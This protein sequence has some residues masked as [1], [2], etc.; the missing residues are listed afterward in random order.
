MG[1]VEGKIEF[2]SVELRSFVFMERLIGF[3][4][5]LGENMETKFIFEK[6]F[7]KSTLDSITKIYT[8]LKDLRRIVKESNQKIVDLVVTISTFYAIL[9]ENSDFGFLIFQNK[10]ILKNLM[11]DEEDPLLRVTSNLC[12]IRVIMALE[13]K[14]DQNQEIQ[15][16]LE[17]GS[18]YLTSQ[19]VHF[20]SSEYSKY[21]VPEKLENDKD[22]S[23]AANLVKKE[24]IKNCQI[25]RANSILVAQFFEIRSP[26]LESI[27][28]AS[29]SQIKPE[30]LHNMIQAAS[31]PDIFLS[32]L[33]SSSF[34]NEVESMI[35]TAYSA[36]ANMMITNLSLRKIDMLPESFLSFE[37][38]YV[39]LA[40]KVQKEAESEKLDLW[41]ER[42]SAPLE[43]MT[44]FFI[45][46]VKY[47]KEMGGDLASQSK[48]K[49]NDLLTI[50]T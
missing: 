37:S 12:I 4:S 45:T 18:R 5:A 14:K 29:L 31:I 17:N 33:I 28:E 34:N 10:E 44:R 9:L 30:I 47:S 27:M 35:F 46:L 50:L 20:Y 6:F 16:F 1:G 23:T 36:L 40:T 32:D 43:K 42:I 15:I 3:C 2:S 13:D 7:Q 19:I 21:R 49:V 26:A 48:V 38:E 8:T 25:L 24:A 11:L 39:K 41:E 22:C